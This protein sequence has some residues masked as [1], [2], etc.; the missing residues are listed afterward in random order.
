MGRVRTIF[1]SVK[2]FFTSC[3]VLQGTREP[4][5]RVA[6]WMSCA[7]RHPMCLTAVSILENHQVLSPCEIRRCCMIDPSV[8]HIYR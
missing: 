5:A 7:W 2:A 6:W 3:L 8:I 1:H 4:T